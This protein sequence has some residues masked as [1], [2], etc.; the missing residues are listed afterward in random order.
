[1]AMPSDSEAIS[2]GRS[3]FFFKMFFKISGLQSS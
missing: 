1:M 2:D 3:S